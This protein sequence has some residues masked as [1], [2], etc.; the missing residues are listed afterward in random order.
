M[1]APL[2]ATAQDIAINDANFPD[3]NFRKYL[4][5]QDYGAD[6]VITETEMNRITSIS[7]DGKNISS[8]KG[9]EHFAA[10]RILSCI[11]NQLT[12]L[13]VS[14]NTA[15]TILQCPDNQLT[16]LDVSQN[17]ALTFFSCYGNQLTSLDVSQN[18]VL[19]SLQ[20]GY[21]PLTSLDVSQNTALT[22]FSCYGAQLTSLDVSQNTALT[23]LQC[24]SN[25]LT[26][27]DVSSNTAL[28]SLRCG[29]NQLTSLDVSQNVELTTLKCGLNLL[30]A[31]DVSKC[32]VLT[33]L[34]CYANLL[35]SLDVSQNTMLTDL[36]C[37][38][39]QIK[40]ETMDVFINSLPQNANK[41]NVLHIIC[42]TALS[43]YYYPDVTYREG[44][45]LTK[46]QVAAAKEKGWIA[47]YTTEL[48]NWKEYEGSDDESSSISLPELQ[49]G[50]ATI[51]TL[52]GQK[53]TTPVKGGI[54]IV[55]GK[56]VIVK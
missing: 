21:N 26:T 49:N 36:Y 12:A 45:V 30:T 24:Q 39:N 44:N 35:T 43:S 55:D 18:T 13:D 34:D 41:N 32:T 20:C 3:A 51:Y 25:Y 42:S 9:I 23:S 53:V 2:T 33:E 27:L 47:Y 4:L 17:T 14:K 50:T 37:Y 40:G 31:L 56:K 28:T 1:C 5:E 10:L 11:N 16:S 7:V 54:Y 19:T 52:H 48:D 38:L 46:A 22:S 29:M 6:G 15:L 8:L